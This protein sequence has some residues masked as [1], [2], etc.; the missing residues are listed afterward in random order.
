MPEG[1]LEELPGRVSENDPVQA[2]ERDRRTAQLRQAIARLPA[3]QQ[4]TLVLK[5]YGELKYEEISAV[6]R[7]PVGTAKANF[8]HAV[9]RLRKLLDEGDG[10]A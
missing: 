4:Q 3:K 5:V 2:L 1:G 10:I 7:C 6:M 9:K 8:Y